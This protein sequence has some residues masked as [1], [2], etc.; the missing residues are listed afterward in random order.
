MATLK[1]ALIEYT[2]DRLENLKYGEE[3][4][5]QLQR[6]FAS[7]EEFEQITQKELTL[8]LRQWKGATYNRYVAALTH[9]FRWARLHEYTDLRP[10]F[11][12]KRE[13]SRDDVLTLDQLGALYAT[14]EYRGDWAGFCRQLILT[15]QRV[16]EVSGMLEDHID[17]EVWRIPE[18]KNGTQHLVHLVRQEPIT[19][20]GKTT[21]ADMKRRW[22]Q[23][24]GIPLNNRLHDIR[25][26]FATHMVEG[27][28]DP[29]VVDRILNHCGG[30]KG[31]ARVYNRATMLEA[32]RDV[33]QLWFETLGV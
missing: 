4:L 13:V 23:D 19:W 33:M 30:A 22:F 18:T 12:R 24:A 1:Q 10:E 7:L 14:A 29:M 31:V 20:T 8:V 32:R 21:F 5:R 6:V 17:D 11:M 15:G 16:G 26:S 25:R 9:F 2:E 3:R 27:G 28:A